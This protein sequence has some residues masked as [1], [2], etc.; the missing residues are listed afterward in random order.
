MPKYLVTD[1]KI[2]WHVER[3]RGRIQ[4]KFKGIR[5]AKPFLPSGAVEF[6]SAITMLQGPKPVYY[7]SDKKVLSTTWKGS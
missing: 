2:D 3:D 5:G 6:L 7:D 1:Y 4:F